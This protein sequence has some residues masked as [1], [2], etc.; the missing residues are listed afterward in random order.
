M[1]P[2]RPNEGN[3]QQGR[4]AMKSDLHRAQ[5]SLF[6]RIDF[7]QA[8]RKRLVRK[9]KQKEAQ[10]FVSNEVLI[11]RQGPNEQAKIYRATRQGAFNT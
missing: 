8:L 11:I 6:M 2:N 4:R 5:V 10:I 3:S 7:P 1:R 9:Y